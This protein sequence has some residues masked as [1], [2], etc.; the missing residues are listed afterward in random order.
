MPDRAVVST[1]D[2]VL[3]ERIVVRSVAADGVKFA[4]ADRWTW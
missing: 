2:R 1:N 4:V 3:T